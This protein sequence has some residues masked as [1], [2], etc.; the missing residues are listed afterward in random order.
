M[1]G[2]GDVLYE[3]DGVSKTYRGM[4]R[5]V[6]NVTLTVRVGDFIGVLGKN[7]SGKSTLVK[8]MV[9]LVRPDTGRV[10]FLGE[11]LNGTP[12][13]V[14]YMPQS[15][16]ALNTLTVREALIV[17]SYLRGLS[18]SAARLEASKLLEDFEIGSYADRVANRL[19]GGERRMLQIAVCMAGSPPVLILDEPTN[20]LD[21]GRRKLIW[22]HLR[23]IHKEGRT[24]VLIT[25][26]AL[27]ADR[28]IDSVL[29]MKEGRLKALNSLSDLRRADTFDLKVR[30]RSE[31]IVNLGVTT[32]MRTS[33]VDYEYEVLV[34]SSE[35][36]DVLERLRASGVDEVWVTP[37]TLED[38]Y[39]RLA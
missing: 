23:Q 13:A 8:M 9:G 26:N 36:G 27:E 14:G 32:P 22:S 16:F 25:H 31:T 10:S 30:F 39:E 21:I 17:V 1:T 2:I 28:Y 34:H 19:S 18:W 33:D 37:V 11:T 24:I 7:G 12:A 3:V 29:I 38:L 15:G 4:I 6:N 5:A 35:V 20:E